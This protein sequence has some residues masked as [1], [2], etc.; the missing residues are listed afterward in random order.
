[1]FKA[2]DKWLP[3]YLMRQRPR[4][5]GE[6]PRLVIAVCDHFEPFHGVDKRSALDRVDTWN[7]AFREIA[8]QFADSD[9]HPPK[10]TFFYPIEQADDE[11]VS[12]I[13]GLCRATGSETEIHLHHEGDDA[14]SLGEILAQG[15]HMLASHGLLGEDRRFAFIH[16]NWALDNSHPDGRHCGVSGELGVLR[17]AGCYGDFT[18]P[19]APSPTQTRTINSIYYATSSHRPKSHDFGTPV[20]QATTGFRDDPTKLLMIQGP[21]GLNWGWR[22]FGIMP[23][24]ENGD[25]TGANPPTMNRLGVWRRISPRIEHRGDV[26]FV[27][28]HTHGAIERNSSMLLGR[29][30]RDFHR[31]L[32]GSG[33]DYHYV[34]AREMVNIIHAFEDGRSGMPGDYRNYLH[35]RTPA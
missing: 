15:Q 28:L 31:L 17:A 20:S 30:M 34:T 18:M 5:T 16:G 19:S 3:P 32:A 8:G 27:K 33:A 9:G 10:H 25:L 12:G 21:L 24:V 14:K 1:M 26:I 13:A 29:P 7:K 2:I 4:S 23:R 35:Q 11:I 6:R 22:K